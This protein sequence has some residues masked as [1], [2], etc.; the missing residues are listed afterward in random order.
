MNHNIYVLEYL[1]KTQP[2]EDYSKLEQYIKNYIQMEEY[3][4]ILQIKYNDIK[5][6]NIKIVITELTAVTLDIIFTYH[7][8][9]E[10]SHEFKCNTNTTFNDIDDFI[11]K[12]SIEFEKTIN[13]YHETSKKDYNNFY[14]KK[15]YF[16]E[17]ID[18]LLEKL[19]I[20]D[21][22]YRRF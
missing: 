21:L 8:L 2:N 11:M 22:F 20:K 13:E 14:L 3:M 19:D 6:Y 5:N 4:N 17:T 12:N 18:E 16:H 9:F 15:K 1:K 10:F 7:H